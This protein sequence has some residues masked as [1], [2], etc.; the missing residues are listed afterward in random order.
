MREAVEELTEALAL[1]FTTTFEASRPGEAL[2]HVV[3]DVLP[4]RLAHE[5]ER[6]LASQGRKRR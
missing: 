1:C 2:R 6:L 4:R 5:I 3:A